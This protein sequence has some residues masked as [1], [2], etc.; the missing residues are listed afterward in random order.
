MKNRYFFFFL[1]FL[2][3]YFSS[4]VTLVA[5]ETPARTESSDVAYGPGERLVYKLSY[6]G[7][8]AGSAVMEVLKKTYVNGRPVYPVLSTVKSNKFVS[9]FY[10]VK[11]RIETLID[12]EDG[13]S[14]GIK[15]NQ[16]QGR[17]KRDKVI[18]FDQVRHRAT[19]FKNN[20]VETFQIPPRVQDSLSSLYHFRRQTV[21]EVGKSTFIDVHESNKNWELEIKVLA[22]EKITTALGTFNTFKVK[23]YVRYEGLFMDKGDVTLWLTDDARHIPVLIKTKIK[24]G[25]IT[26]VLESSES[27]TPTYQVKADIQ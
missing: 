26:A 21:F 15:I 1:A 11:D 4:Y 24:I 14:H 17:K 9:A 8:P 22:R 19:Q 5:S 3:F 16:R 7:V 25:S 18:N 12:V 27:P 13:Y 6:L 20:K 2:S 23:A 10:P